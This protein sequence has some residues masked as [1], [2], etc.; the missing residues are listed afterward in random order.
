MARLEAENA[1]LREQLDRAFVVYREQALELV[2]LR[3]RLDVILQAVGTE[4]AE[5]VRAEV[6]PGF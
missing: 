2:E 6:A 3:A 1:R 4:P 5:R